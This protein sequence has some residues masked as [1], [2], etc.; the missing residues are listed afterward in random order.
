VFHWF[1]RHFTQFSFLIFPSVLLF[2]SKMRSYPLLVAGLTGSAFSTPLSQRQT[3]TTSAQSWDEIKPSPDLN[4]QSCFQNYTCARL[5]VPLD[6]ASH[7]ITGTATIAYIRQPATLNSSSAEDVLINPGGPGESG[8]DTIMSLGSDLAQIIGPQF[9]LIGFD[10]RGVGLSGPELSCFGSDPA[11]QA[12]M[13]A[14][15]KEFIRPVDGKSEKDLRRQYALAEG[16]GKRCTEYNKGTDAKYANTV[17]VAS[18]MLNYV[19]KAA[20]LK[21]CKAEDAKVNY[22]GEFPCLTYTVIRFPLFPES[23]Y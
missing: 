15:Q 1:Y 18:D 6:Y 5:T 16:F 4:W 21:G 19:E 22:Y 17:A 10:P 13:T 9:N 2:I 14:Y 3:N 7:N 23:Y 11:S 12:N 8:V 20:V